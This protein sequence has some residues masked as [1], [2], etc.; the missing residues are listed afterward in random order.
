MAH[1]SSPGEFEQ[2]MLLALAGFER[3]S[4][5]GEIYEVLVEE[6]EREVSLAAVYI[7]LTRMNEKGWVGLRTELPAPDRG[8]RPRKFFSLSPAGADLLR[9]LRQQFDRLWHRAAD[10]PYLAAGKPKRG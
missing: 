1:G 2:L 7:T 3:E 5:A 8:G 4:T 9:G 6:T 10:H